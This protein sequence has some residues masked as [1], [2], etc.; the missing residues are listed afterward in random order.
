MTFWQGL[1]ISILGQSIDAAGAD[2]EAWAA[3]SQNFLICL[4]MLLFSLAHYYCF[5]TDEW[6]ENYKVNYQ[7]LHLGD[8]IALGDFFSDLKLVMSK[9]KSNKKKKIQRIPSQPTVAEGDEENFNDDATADEDVTADEDATADEESAHDDATA[10]YDSDDQDD[11]ESL[12]T[13]VSAQSGDKAEVGEAQRRMNRFLE[14]MAFEA[15]TSPT[16]QTPPDGIEVGKDTAGPGTPGFASPLKPS[17]FTDVADKPPM[18]QDVTPKASDDVATERTGLLSA[19]SPS[20][21]KPSFFSRVADIAE[22]SSSSADEET[23]SKDE[24]KASC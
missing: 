16:S 10:E 13:T 1:A 20:L 9:K 8:S 18:N 6:Q 4:E 11:D 5:P 23:A 22:K 12:S 3:K 2:P 19:Q 17:A 24:E 15:H 14:D 21:L 7:K